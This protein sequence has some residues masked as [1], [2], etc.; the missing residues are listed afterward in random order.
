[1]SWSTMCQPDPPHISSWH[2]LNCTALSGMPIHD[3]H[4]P[5][6]PTL[7]HDW[8][9]DFIS[10]VSWL[11]GS[12]CLVFNIE[13]VNWGLWLIS[14]VCPHQA[15]KDNIV[16]G[17]HSSIYLPLVQ[18]ITVWIFIPLFNMPALSVNSVHSS[19]STLHHPNAI[20]KLKCL[21]EWR[22]IK[23]TYI[24]HFIFN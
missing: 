10:W 19:R 4:S 5:G 2:T 7:N 11:A 9:T 20:M 8:W 17:I 6:S 14:N 12:S 23:Y 13:K 24:E 15:A 16:G 1:M 18:W 3:F 22:I 21:T